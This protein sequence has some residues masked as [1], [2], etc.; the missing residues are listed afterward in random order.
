MSIGQIRQWNGRPIGRRFDV[1]TR[2]IAN[3]LQRDAS[4]A[5]CARANS[6]LGLLY[7]ATGQ[8]VTKL[9]TAVHALIHVVA[10]WVDCNVCLLTVPLSLL[11]S[12]CA[13]GEWMTA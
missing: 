12:F 8:A 2:S 10:D 11:L 6:G 1:K 5:V 4:P 13:R 7:S 9:G 3:D